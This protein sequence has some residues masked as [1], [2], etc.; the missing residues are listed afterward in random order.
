MDVNPIHVSPVFAAYSQLPGTVTHGM[1]TSAAVR[2]IVER[3]VAEADYSRFRSFS[4]SFEGMVM[5]GDVLRVELQHTAIIDG[6]KVLKVQAYNDSTNER[7]L[8]AEAEVEQAPTAYLFCGQGSQEKGMG[9]A[10]YNTSPAARALW[11]KGDRYLL[12][13]YGMKTF[14]TRGL[15]SVAKVSFRFLA[16]RHRSE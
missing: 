10:L 11:N 2:R 7:V 9:M 14:S 3:V 15:S 16:P 4:A 6:K 12:D 13:L 5:P 8:G 1:F